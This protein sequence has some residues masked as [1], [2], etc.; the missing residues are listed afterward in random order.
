MG[1]CDGRRCAPRL[2][3]SADEARVSKTARHA[4]IQRTCVTAGESV[5]I[6]PEYAAPVRMPQSLA[7]LA[8]TGTSPVLGGGG[9]S[10]GSRLVPADFADATHFNEGMIGVALRT[11]SGSG[12]SPLCMPPH[13][14]DRVGCQGVVLMRFESAPASNYTRLGSSCT[15]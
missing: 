4:L 8:G 12:M 6:I 9:R 11:I 2:V 10:S 5:V 14:G 7:L 1:T 3:P 15:G 13:R